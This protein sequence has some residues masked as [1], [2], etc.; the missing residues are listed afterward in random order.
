M[1]GGIFNLYQARS[2][3]PNF[4]TA[5]IQHGRQFIFLKMASNLYFYKKGR[6]SGKY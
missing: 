3:L 5:H 6:Q 2:D 4:G 1:S